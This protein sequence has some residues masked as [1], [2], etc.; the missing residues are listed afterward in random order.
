MLNESCS[1]KSTW[2]L[3]KNKTDFTGFILQLQGIKTVF[4]KNTFQNRFGPLA[5]IFLKTLTGALIEIY[6][7]FHKVVFYVKLSIFLLRMKKNGFSQKVF[8]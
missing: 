7:S 6:L 5:K 2:L 3:Y 8:Q 4:A 1:Y